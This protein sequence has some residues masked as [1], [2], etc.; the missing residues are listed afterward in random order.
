MFTED[1]LINDILQE[2]IKHYK[3]IP[4]MYNNGYL[5]HH[6]RLVDA[7]LKRHTA[8]FRSDVNLDIKDVF[9]SLANLLQYSIDGESENSTSV[10]ELPLE[11]MGTPRNP[12]LGA[13]LWGTRLARCRPVL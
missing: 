8:W 5:R 12:V 10:A 3:D 11:M 4:P 6:T 1:S 7:Y 13:Y 9:D 2:S